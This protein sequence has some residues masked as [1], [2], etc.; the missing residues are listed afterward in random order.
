MLK[1]PSM[2]I[3]HF[4]VNG[5]ERESREVSESWLAQVSANQENV[6][7]ADGNIYQV[8]GVQHTQEGHARIELVAPQFARGS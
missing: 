7:L 3:A 6:L 1:A 8:T 5:S 2:I 4:I